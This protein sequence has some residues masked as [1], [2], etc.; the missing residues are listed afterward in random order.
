MSENWK[1]L[2]I[3]LISGMVIAVV[4]VALNWSSGYPIIHKLCDGFFVAAVVLL[5]V[6]GLKVARNAGNF[7]MI[8]YGVK[9]ALYI[10][11]P[12][13]KSNSPLEHKEEDFVSYKE[14]KR[15]ERKPANDLLIAGVVYLVLASMLLIVYLAVV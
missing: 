5:G 3:S 6:G 14:R 7:D 8:S 2:L 9:S 1:K 13:L 10:T 12:W 15:G 11:L 4:V